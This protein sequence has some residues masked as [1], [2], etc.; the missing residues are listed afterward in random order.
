MTTTV[1]VMYPREQGATFDFDYYQS[2]HLP[3]VAA[4]WAGAGLTGAEAMKGLGAPGGGEA[5]FLA[6]ALIRFGSM[7]A[8]EAALNGEHAA[9][10]MGDIANFTNVQP[11]IQVNERI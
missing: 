7:A 11:V 10:I 8:F 6:I 5:P 4:R 3:L 9:E 2:T 1:T